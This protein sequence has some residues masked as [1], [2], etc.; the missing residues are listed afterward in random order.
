MR[1][2][3]IP[4]SGA[5]RE[6]SAAQ[7]T[8]P[9]SAFALLHEV[10][11]RM[12]ALARRNEASSIDLR[13][14]PMCA[15]DRAALAELLG[16]GSVFARVEAA[17]VTEVRET[18]FPGVWWVAHANEAGEVLAEFIDV[19]AVPEILKAGR[20]DVEEGLERLRLSLKGARS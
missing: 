6:A 8:K 1:L 13:G 10:G 3:A 20:E 16:S 19:C 17:G 12:E 14:L 11:S 9:G 7:E 15:Q 2:D 18:A 4:A 5:P